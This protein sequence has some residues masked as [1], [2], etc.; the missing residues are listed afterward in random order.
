MGDQQWAET[1]AQLRDGFESALDSL[2]HDCQKSGEIPP[3][4]IEEGYWADY[5][6]LKRS[7]PDEWK[8][9]D[10][11]KQKFFVRL[12]RIR[13]FSTSSTYKWFRKQTWKL[14]GVL[15]APPRARLLYLLLFVVARFL[16]RVCSIVIPKTVATVFGDVR[17]YVEP[18]GE[19]EKAIVQRIDKRV[20]EDLLRMLGLDWN[21]NKLPPKAMIQI[22]GKPFEFKRIVW[23]AHSLGSVISYNVLSDLFARSDEFEWTGTAEQKKGVEKFR[24]ALQ[25]FVTLGSPLDKIATL[26][27][28]KVLRPWKPAQYTVGCTKKWWVNFYHVLDPVSGA[29]NH[30]EICKRIVPHNHHIG[31]G[32]GP[33]VAHTGY[34][35]DPLVLEYI[36]SRTY[37]RDLLE[38]MVDGNWPP[39]TLTLL[40]TLGYL[41]WFVLIL[42]VLLGVMWPMVKYL[43]LPVFF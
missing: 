40:A 27:P 12:W 32:H 9:L 17:L 43:I 35:K 38:L 5:G 13:L 14:L 1:A 11:P 26:F 30:P 28:G 34:W 18:H 25:R 21:F 33:G 36:L 7:F 42:G 8:R 22:D 16:L 23:V 10:E 19:I 20:G 6:S 37:G 41:V 39:G 3:P 24:T 29:L 31:I 2:A 4:F 15:N